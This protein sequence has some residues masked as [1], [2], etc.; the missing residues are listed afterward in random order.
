MN[1]T[2]TEPRRRGR[3]KTDNPRSN[4]FVLRL[5]NDELAAIDGKAQK[6]KKVRADWVR[7][8]LLSA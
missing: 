1:A 7:Q 6:A 3:P 4:G 2:N 8:T 5:T